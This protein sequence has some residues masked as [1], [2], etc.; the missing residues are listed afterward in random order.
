M[1]D[2]PKIYVDWEKMK[3]HVI[4]Y[5]INTF[6]CLLPYNSNFRYFETKPL[7]RKTLNL[8]DSAVSCIIFVLILC[9]INR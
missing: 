1:Y 6:L 4:I 7:V 2:A 3:K 9:C 8:R 5:G